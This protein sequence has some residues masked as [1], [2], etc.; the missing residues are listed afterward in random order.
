MHCEAC[1]AKIGKKTKFCPKCGNIIIKEE[2]SGIEQKQEEIQNNQS[3]HIGFWKNQNKFGK[4][5]VII[6]AVFA[7]LFLI[8]AFNGKIVAAIFAVFQI[9][10]CVISLLIINN[11]IK[12]PQQ[13]LHII[14]SSIALILIFPYIAA[15]N[16]SPSNTQ[17]FV[18]SDIVLNEILP[19]PKTTYGQIELNDNDNLLIYISKISNND[20]IEYL[21]KCEEKGFK[22]EAEKTENNYKSFNENGYKLNLSY[23]GDDKQM[24]IDLNAPIKL[25]E[26]KWSNSE[27]S[28][29]IPVPQFTK[30]KIEKDDATEYTLYLS[31]IS[32][33]EYEEYINECMNSGFNAD[34]SSDTGLFCAKNSD[35]Y[36]LT[37]N[38]E[39]NNIIYI[40]LKEP[41]YNID[42]EVEYCDELFD[43][44]YDV[45]IYI[46]DISI[47]TIAHGTTDVYTSVLNRDN[48]T[49]MFVN[50]DNNS[51]SNEVR[52]KI[53][54]QET[55]K[56]K[57]TCNI[58]EIKVETIAGTV[59]IQVT[60]IELTSSSDIT[61]YD[62]NSTESKK[63]FSV[64]TDSD[65]SIITNYD[66]F[67]DFVSD[68]PNIA[69]IR[70]DE[71]S[72]YYPSVIISPIS[73]GETYVY[74]QSKDKKIKS[75]KVKVVVGKIEK[76]EPILEEK[77]TIA[78]YDETTTEKNSGITVYITPTGEKYHYSKSC[79]G[80][81]AIEKDLND[82]QGIYDPCKKCAR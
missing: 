35:D 13:K 68:N 4:A 66:E 59:D 26:I 31:E 25:T 82:V 16:S 29:L 8:A 70:Y 46:D 33:A 75:E 77:T 20:Y 38:Y 62:L 52:L 61:F 55:L 41:E 14:L 56:F 28:E 24:C 80:K 74:I 58:D 45:D 2:K 72:M 71:N 22:I 34:I 54:K 57:I 40:S 10:L 47:G 17:S 27:I 64:E 15:L 18:W 12:A 67:V 7:L 21:T 9:F 32:Y 81:N 6:T 51:I 60:S 63:Y 65:N 53:N 79:A 76:T 36:T 69:T 49:I 37:V 23:Y 42:V 50:T 43:S 3:D 1:G 48:H 30:G 39:G 19:E 78:A 5:L 11:K 44:D 73:P